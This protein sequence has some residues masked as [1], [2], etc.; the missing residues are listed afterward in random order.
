MGRKED[1][2]KQG[3][4]VARRAGKGAYTGK[5]KVFDY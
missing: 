1:N 4:S 2:Q 3:F 5:G